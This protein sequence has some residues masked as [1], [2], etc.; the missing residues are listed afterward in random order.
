MCRRW[1]TRRRR[2]L[3]LGDLVGLS[4]ARPGAYD[5]AVAEE[6]AAV[7]DDRSSEG[8]EA[9]GRARGKGHGGDAAAREPAWLKQAEEILWGVQPPGQA[10]ETQAMRRR[11]RR[12][13]AQRL[14]L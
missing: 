3:R 10:G 9:R 13:A 1:A 14:V 8:G 11:R 6:L 2:W 4:T 12:L 5:R 7:A